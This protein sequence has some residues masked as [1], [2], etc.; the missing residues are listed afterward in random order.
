LKSL[1][2]LICEVCGKKVTSHS[3]LNR[4]IV[5]GHYF[6]DKKIAQFLLDLE[7][8]HVAKEKVEFT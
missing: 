8:S 3:E 7:D 6:D 1:T 4:E 5:R 2:P